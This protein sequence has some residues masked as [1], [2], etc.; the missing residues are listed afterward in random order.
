MDPNRIQPMMLSQAGYILPQPGLSLVSPLPGGATAYA[1][2]PSYQKSLYFPLSFA[3][4]NDPQVSEMDFSS[5]QVQSTYTSPA[6]VLEKDYQIV[7]YEELEKLLPEPK[8]SGRVEL[9]LLPNGCAYAPKTA[10]R[11]NYLLFASKYS[12]ILYFTHHYFSRENLCRDQTFLNMLVDRLILPIEKL[13]KA[14]RLAALNTTHEEVEKALLGSKIVCVEDMNAGMRGVRRIDGYPGL[15]TNPDTSINVQSESGLSTFTSSQNLTSLIGSFSL[16]PQLPD[17]QITTS[18]QSVVVLKTAG[19]DKFRSDGVIR[20]GH[21]NSETSKELLQAST[22]IQNPVT[23]NVCIAPA[24]HQMSIPLLLPL[25]GIENCSNIHIECTGTAGPSVAPCRNTAPWIL[26][27]PTKQHNPYSRVAHVIVPQSINQ[28]NSTNYNKNQPLAWDFHQCPH[29]PAANST[30]SSVVPIRRQTHLPN[31]FIRQTGN[32][33]ESYPVPFS[34]P[35][36]SN[37]NQPFNLAVAAALASMSTSTSNSINPNHYGHQPQYFPNQLLTNS[38]NISPIGANQQRPSNALLNHL[39]AV[40]A[41]SAV[42]QHSNATPYFQNPVSQTNPFHIPTPVPLPVYYTAPQLSLQS[43]GAR[44]SL[45]RLQQNVYP[46]QSYG[47]QTVQNVPVSES[48]DNLRSDSRCGLTVPNLPQHTNNLIYPILLQPPVHIQHK[49]PTHMNGTGWQVHNP[50]QS[51]RGAFNS[52]GLTPIPINFTV[53]NTNGSTSVANN[54]MLKELPTFSDTKDNLDNNT[55]VDNMVSDAAINVSLASENQLD[56]GSSVLPGL[57]SSTENFTRA[58]I[59][60]NQ[61]HKLPKQ[62]EKMTSPGSVHDSEDS[63]SSGIG[64]MTATSTGDNDSRN[65]SSC[66]PTE[67][68]RIIPK[69]DYVR[70]KSSTRIKE[71]LTGT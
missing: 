20:S 38:S 42:A 8:P 52:V 60:D 48:S 67:P 7:T 17:Q 45:Q 30:H 23:T 9:G 3:G 28:T 29:L 10:S 68:T 65:N 40:A 13:V 14:P 12:Y 70:N 33:I 35:Q 2:Q 18:L 53:I 34:I 44:N 31:Y 55:A 64:D 27:R 59:G 4:Y 1:H 47:Y 19:S 15:S 5:S 36:T 54:G 69:S 61:S 46:M 50:G 66:T 37:T 22:L 32:V 49:L 26:Q 43:S 51:I 41:M 16:Q 6:D 39:Q 57:I 56:S 62:V 58:V 11:E 71:K 24:S 25:C 63:V 21:M